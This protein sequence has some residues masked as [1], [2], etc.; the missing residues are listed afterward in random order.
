MSMYNYRCDYCET[1]TPREQLMTLETYWFNGQIRD[2]RY[3]CCNC[4]KHIFDAV[5]KQ[6]RESKKDG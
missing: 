2:I 4:E 6:K 1:I 5:E 3:L